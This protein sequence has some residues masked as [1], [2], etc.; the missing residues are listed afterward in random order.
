MQS[1]IKS[2][3]SSIF[4]GW[5]IVIVAAIAVFFSGPGQTYGVS[6]FIDYYIQEF[7]W[8]RSLVSGIYSTATLAAGL[9][10]FLVGR[11]IDKLGQR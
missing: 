4:Y 7:G 5:Y 10:L 6:V 2:Q 9:L 8:S 1:S 11:L 3:N